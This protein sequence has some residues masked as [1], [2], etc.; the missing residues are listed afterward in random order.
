M[1]KVILAGGSFAGH[2]RV[3]PDPDE[4]RER[5]Y[6][7]HKSAHGSHA[8]AVRFCSR[9]RRDDGPDRPFALG[10]ELQNCLPGRRANGHQS[11]GSPRSTFVEERRSRSDN[12]RD[13]VRDACFFQQ[14]HPDHRTTMLLPDVPCPKAAMRA[15]V[16]SLEQTNLGIGQVLPGENQGRY[17]SKRQGPSGRIQDRRVGHLSGSDQ[18]RGFRL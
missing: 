11:S 14:A 5:C 13:K 7:E 1:W 17:D 15:N 2:V 10:A 16:P 8:G 4:L 3:V 12:P 18:L 9:E 6:C